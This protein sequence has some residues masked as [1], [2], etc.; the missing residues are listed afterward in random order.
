MSF[1]Q[2]KIVCT[3]LETVI[4]VSPVRLFKLKMNRLK[5]VIPNKLTEYLKFN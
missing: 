5:T 2:V 4:I 1:G 3:R